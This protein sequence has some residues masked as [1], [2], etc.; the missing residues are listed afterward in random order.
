ME[1][2]EIRVLVGKELALE[3]IEIQRHPLHDVEFRHASSKKDVRA[4]EHAVLVDRDEFP[5]SFGIPVDVPQIAP[6][7]AADAL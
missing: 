6:H 3:V 4:P 7:V 1:A 5:E 2:G